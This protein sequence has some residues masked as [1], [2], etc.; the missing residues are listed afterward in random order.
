MKVLLQ[1]WPT[2]LWT[3]FYLG[4]TIS[5]SVN[6]LSNYLGIYY[7]NVFRLTLILEI[8]NLIPFYRRLR[9]S[10]RKLWMKDTNLDLSSK[11]TV[12]NL[13]YTS[14]FWI[15]KRLWSVYLARAKF[16]L[17]L[18]K[19]KY[20]YLYKE[21]KGKF[22]SNEIKTSLENFKNCKTNSCKVNF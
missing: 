16:T 5:I 14:L 12:K 9:L 22:R 1:L 8:V 4:Q 10:A 18:F 2:F 3:T 11:F 20:L 17:D 21:I 13:L 15:F 7:K 6:V 19:K